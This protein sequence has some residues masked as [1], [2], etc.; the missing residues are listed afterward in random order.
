M[1]HVNFDFQLAC[2]RPAFTTH[3]L[4]SKIST[5]EI[6]NPHTPQRTLCLVKCAVATLARWIT[7]I[8]RSSH[9][10][11]VLKTFFFLRPTVKNILVWNQVLGYFFLKI[12]AIFSIISMLTFVNKNLVY[13][14]VTS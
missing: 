13:E 12:V 3:V 4:Q 14:P 1:K 2:G 11:I 10:Q 5:F 6:L 9:L 7:Q 8:V